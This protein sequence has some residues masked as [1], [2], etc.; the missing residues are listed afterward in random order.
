MLALRFREFVFAAR[1]MF[2][3]KIAAAIPSP[4]KTTNTIAR[5]PTIHGHVLRLL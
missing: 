2:G 4:A 3:I 1:I 5:I